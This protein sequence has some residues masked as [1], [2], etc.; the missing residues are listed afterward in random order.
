M[1]S[2]TGKR[3]SK[4]S[5]MYCIYVRNHVLNTVSI[6][7]ILLHIR[8]TTIHLVHAEFMESKLRDEVVQNNIQAIKD[9]LQVPIPWINHLTRSEL[10]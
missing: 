2:Y 9:E 7:Q 10:L 1:L 3:C 5:V 8:N 6:L 4:H